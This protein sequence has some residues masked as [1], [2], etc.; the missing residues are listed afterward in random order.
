MCWMP[1]EGRFDVAIWAEGRGLITGR[2]DDPD[3]MLRSVLKNIIIF[4]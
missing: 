4:C 2:D 3:A 1:S